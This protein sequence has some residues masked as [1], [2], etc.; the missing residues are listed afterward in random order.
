MGRVDTAAERCFSLE[1]R[2]IGTFIG[3]GR[4]DSAI[5]RFVVV[6][7]GDPNQIEFL[8][9]ISIG[10]GFALSGIVFVVFVLSSQRS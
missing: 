6:E 7:A 2:Q 9:P 8:V 10:K 1:A 5:G 3:M 4:G